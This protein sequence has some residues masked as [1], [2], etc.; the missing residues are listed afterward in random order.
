MRGWLLGALLGGSLALACPPEGVLCLQPSFR[1]ELALNRLEAQ[2]LTPGGAL[3]A[4]L[5]LRAQ[6]AGVDYSFKLG[7]W[8][9]EALQWGLLEAQG[10]TRLGPVWLAYGKRTG[11]G[12]PWDETFL[13][14]DGRWGVFARYEGL[15]AAYLPHPGLVGGE[16]YLGLQ[17]AGLEAG[18]FLEVAAGTL[19]LNPRVGW[20][21]PGFA[22]YWQAERGFWGRLALPFG[23]EGF[24]WWS[25]DGGLWEQGVWA[26][27]L[28][29]R[30]LLWA[31]GYTPDERLGLG[32]QVSQAPV[33]AARLYLRFHLR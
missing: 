15:S 25:P 2:P 5:E 20:Q 11:L 28:R 6:E 33:E 22:L 13:G 18:G 29:P 7:L 3:G 21:G 24:F 23:L 30:K 8:Y 31:L 12:G 32:L 1:L 26:W 27:L 14:P 4:L 10:S 19:R 9:A 16:L 17:Q